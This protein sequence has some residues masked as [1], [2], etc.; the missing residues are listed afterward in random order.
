IRA[1]AVGRNV[2]GQ[3]LL[4]AIPE[5]KDQ[6]LDELLVE[7]MRTG[8]P[9]VG[10][11]QLIK[12][13]TQDTYWTFLYAPLPRE[14]S[15][16]RRVIAIC[17][18]VTEQVQARKR[19]EVLASMAEAANRTKDEFLAM[20]GHELRNPLSPILMA[21]QLMRLRGTPSREQDIIERQVGHLTRLVDDLLDISRITRGKIE[22]RRRHIELA[23]VIARAVEMTSP[24]LEQRRD[25]LELDVP[26]SGLVLNADPDRVA[27]VFSN[28][29]NNAAKYSEPGSRIWVKAEHGGGKV[30]V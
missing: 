4:S 24:L 22:L 10:R 7:V 28:L 26:R 6:G 11:D 12:A 18:D 5:L 29:L 1:V 17:T 19:L 3:P 30:R 2:R 21:L 14:D 13:P 8:L 9:L 27:Q 20:L 15:D 23:D 16:E 25:C